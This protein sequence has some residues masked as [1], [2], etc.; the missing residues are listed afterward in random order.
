MRILIIMTMCI[1]C[2]TACA[3]AGSQQIQKKCKTVDGMPDTFV[4]QEP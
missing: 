2:L 1:M 4:C 3:T